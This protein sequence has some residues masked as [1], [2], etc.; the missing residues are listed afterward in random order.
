MPSITTHV[1]KCPKVNVH[2]DVSIKARCLH[3]GQSLHPHLFFVYAS[4]EGSDQSAHMLIL[5]QNAL[6]YYNLQIFHAA[7]SRKYILKISVR[8]TNML[9]SEHAVYLESV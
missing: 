7:I 2:D 1:H 6:N 8:G 4:S 5:C 9:T 3:F